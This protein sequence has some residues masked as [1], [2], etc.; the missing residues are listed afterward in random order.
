MKMTKQAK[1]GLFIFTITASGLALADCPNTMSE[2]LLTDCI[3]NEGAGRS[4]P[5]GDYANIDLYKN[6]M[7]AQQMEQTNALAKTEK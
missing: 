7:A 5:P 4:F 2:Q 1:V 6:W 3:V